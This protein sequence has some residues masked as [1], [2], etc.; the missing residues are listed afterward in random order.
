MDDE[1]KLIDSLH[2]RIA[3]LSGHSSEG[4]RVAPYV[5]LWG[6]WTV[7]RINGE[8]DFERGE[9]LEFTPD[10]SL[11]RRDADNEEYQSNDKQIYLPESDLVFHY[12]IKGDKL[13]LHHRRANVWVRL[14]RDTEG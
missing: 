11:V 5:R 4:A 8:V 3:F 13:T 9:T 7:E 2:G 14:K 6:R 12:Y 1:K 10:N